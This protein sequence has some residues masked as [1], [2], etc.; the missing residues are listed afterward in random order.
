ENC[1]PAAINWPGAPS[2][3]IWPP[4]TTNTLSAII[5]V[6]SRWAII[7]EVRRPKS[8]SSPCCTTASVGAS[9]D[10]V[11]S[12]RINTLGLATTARAK[13]INWRCPADIRRSEEHT[14]EL[15]S[16]FDLVCSLLL[17]K[18]NK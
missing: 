6:E 16:R 10:D 9:N 14:S 1:P 5:T 7:N 4:S 15:Q 8:S 11:A 13:E 2:S 18:K 3:M 12:S 17:E